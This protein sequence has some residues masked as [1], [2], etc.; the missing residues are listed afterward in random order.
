MHIHFEKSNN[1]RRY[2]VKQSRLQT[3][4]K[5]SGLTQIELSNK[6]GCISEKMLSYFETSRGIPNTYQK[7]KIS[8]ALEVPVEAI[9]PEERSS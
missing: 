2:M 9:W 3:Y 4:R 7:K 1:E 6:T 8:E 5:L